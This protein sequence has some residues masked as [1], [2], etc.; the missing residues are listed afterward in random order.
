MMWKYLTS[1]VFEKA[2]KKH[3]NK[4]VWLSPSIKNRKNCKTEL[5]QVRD[6]FQ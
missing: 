2:W 3:C 4:T 5:E 1:G 6:V